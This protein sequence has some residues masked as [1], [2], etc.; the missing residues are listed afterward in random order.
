MAAVEYV[1]P[2]DIARLASGAW[3]PLTDGPKQGQA[4]LVT[5]KGEEDF[6]KYKGHLGGKIVLLEHTREVEPVDRPLFRRLDRDDLE[7]IAEYPLQKEPDFRE[8]IK[9]FVDFLEL[10]HKIG[11]FL[12]QE[13]VLMVVMPSRDGTHG[14]GSGG[15]I[16][17]DIE[18]DMSSAPYRREKANSLPI[19][20]MAIEDYGRIYRLIMNNVSVRLEANIQTRVTGDHEHAFNTIAE[21]PGREPNIRDQVVMFGA[22]LDSWASATGA[23]D[24]G[25][26]TLI[27]IEVMRILNALDIKPRRTVRIGLWSG[28]EEGLFGSVRY[29][30]QHF[31]SFQLSTDADQLRMPDFYRRPVGSLQVKPDYNRISAYFNLDNGGGRIRDVYSQGNLVA[32][33]I[34]EQW[35][36]PL[37]DLGVTTVA[38]R[39]SSGTDHESFEAIGIPGFQFIQD[40]LDY[41]SRTHH[42]NFDIFEELRSEDLKQAAVVEAIFIYNAAMRNQLFPRKPISETEQPSPN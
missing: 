25:A 7:R 41:G 15:T 23:T 2:N 21:I 17:D 12:A 22:H 20:V 40:S 16:F 19:I 39:G 30:A 38:G 36:R 10:R 4:V 27:G 35:I 37:H 33:A 6:A 28:E 24:D 42:S 3:S 29:V 31:G 9:G 1:D 26:G 14:G 32:E 11:E 34:F 13:N 8:E 5:I 18:S